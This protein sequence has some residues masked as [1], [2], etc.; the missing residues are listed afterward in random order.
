MDVALGLLGMLGF[1]VGI[2]ALASA[3]TFAVVQADG[4]IRR[5]RKPAE[6]AGR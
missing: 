2:L 1:I 3:V 5:R 6:P 4:M